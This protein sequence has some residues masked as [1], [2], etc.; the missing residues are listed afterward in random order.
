MTVI[1]TDDAT[2]THVVSIALQK[3]LTKT[4]EALVEVVQGYVQSEVYDVYEPE[5]GGYQRRHDLFGK[6]GFYESWTYSEIESLGGALGGGRTFVSKIFSDAQDMAFIPEQHVH[7]AYT[8]TGVEVE[9]EWMGTLTQEVAKLVDRRENLDEYI[10]EGT[11]YDFI[12]EEGNAYAKPRDYW[13]PVIDLLNM[14]FLGEMFETVCEEL[15]IP[16]MRGW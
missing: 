6:G 9:D 7:G 5:E 2:L 16:I 10:A 11:N 8:M 1:I 15:G 13:S 12:F 4:M 14:G 3:A